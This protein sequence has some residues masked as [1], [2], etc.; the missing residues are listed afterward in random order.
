MSAE[1]A[2]VHDHMHGSMNMQ[3]L[4]LHVLGD[5]LGNVGVIATG[6]V[7]WLTTWKYK[8]YFDPVISLVITVIIFSSALP[9]GA[10]PHFAF[11][12]WVLILAPPPVRSASFILLQG[13][14]PT[15]SLDEVRESILK[16]NGV[17][18]VHELHIWQLSESKI[19]ASVHVMASRDHDFMPVAV[20]IRRALHHHGIHSST[21]QPEYHPPSPHMIPDDQ[22][23]VRRPASSVKMKVID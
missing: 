6:L 11:S 23:K 21:I 13:V 14:P 19:V 17:L 9:L 15:I 22:L 10:S 18:S 5:A 20:E 1:H 12:T 4:V 16:V 2:H 8:F 3:A 7:I